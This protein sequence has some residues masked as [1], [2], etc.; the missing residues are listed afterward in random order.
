MPMLN[1]QMVYIYIYIFESYENTDMQQTWIQWQWLL[2]IC[3][4][5]VFAVRYGCGS[6]VWMFNSPLNFWYWNYRY[7]PMLMIYH[8]VLKWLKLLTPIAYSNQRWLERISR[9]ATFDN[10][11][12]P[13]AQWTLQAS[14]KLQQAELQ[15]AELQV[16][17]LRGWKWQPSIR[18]CR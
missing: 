6:K 10:R 13:A 14:A 7:S 4:I 8:M 17:M 3:N 16:G 12:I 1:N 18:R 2:Q 9:P 5:K 15:I 11:G